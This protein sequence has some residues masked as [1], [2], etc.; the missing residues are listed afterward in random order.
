[1]IT[2]QD[3]Q[4][5]KK[6]W[7]DKDLG[8]K[9]TDDGWKERSQKSGIPIWQRPFSDDKNDLFRWRLPR[10]AAPHT[11]VFDVFTNKMI[12][13]HHY[14]TAEY[15]GGYVH[16]NALSHLS[17]TKFHKNETIITQNFTAY[18]ANY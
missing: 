2:L 5:N 12:D 13:Y 3:W 11:E 10:V 18:F 6:A 9:T 1:M 4:L 8:L 7:L 16:S 17:Q 14:W 15:T